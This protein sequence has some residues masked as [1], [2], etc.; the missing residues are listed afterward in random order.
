[1]R[2]RVG[3]ESATQTE[4]NEIKRRVILPEKPTDGSDY[5]VGRRMEN[6]RISSAYDPGELR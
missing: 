2:V 1:M 3:S 6:G 4:I 5:G